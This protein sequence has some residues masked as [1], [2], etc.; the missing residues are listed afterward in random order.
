MKRLLVLNLVGLLLAIAS[1]ANAQT[2]VYGTTFE[3]NAA[4]V[5]TNVDGGVSVFVEN[6]K[7]ETTKSVAIIQAPDVGT[8]WVIA[9]DRAKPF[10]PI[11]L[12]AFDKP[13]RFLLDRAGVFDIQILPIVDGAGGV[14]SFI[15]GVTV[16]GPIVIEDPDPPGPID[17]FADIPAI[18]APLIPGDSAV[19]AKALADMYLA[20]DAPTAK[21]IWQDVD[22]NRKEILLL[23]PIRS[24]FWNPFVVK[25]AELINEKKPKGPDEM[26]AFLKAVAAGLEM[27]QSGQS[28]PAPKLPTKP[29]TQYRKPNGE[30]WTPPPVSQMVDGMIHDGMQL[31]L[32]CNGDQCEQRWYPVQR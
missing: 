6:L 24:S 16:D 13:G 11:Y 8:G 7:K 15:E 30:L 5:A 19:T 23:R 26:K 31:D 28:K 22:L 12:P 4:Q 2:V 21:E 10:P 17:R 14:P 32:I 9:Y 27:S 29:T 1:I 3:A 25:L 20:A 18:I